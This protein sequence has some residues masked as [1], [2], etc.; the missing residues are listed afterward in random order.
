[1]SKLYVFGIGGTGSRVLKALTM[2]LSSGVECAVD[3]IVPIII[4]PDDSAADKTR[5][6]ASMNLYMS[7]RENLDFSNADQNRFFKT[8]IMPVDGME[9]FG[10]PLKN[11]R[12]CLFKD[13]IKIDELN[14]ANRALISLLFSEKN[15]NSDMK[16]GFKGNPNIGSVVLNQFANSQEYKDFANGFQQ[17]DRIFIISSIFGGTGASGFPLLLK[18]L[19][20]DRDS[21]SWNLINK[22][23]IGAITVLPYFNVSQDDNSGVDSSTFA[24]KTKSALAYYEH[25]I[26]ANG[27]VDALYYIGDNIP[28]S[29]E[30][31][32]GGSEQRNNAHII[33]LCSALAILKFAATPDSELSGDTL[34][35]EYGLDTNNTDI[36]QIIFSDLG[37]NTQVEIQKPMTQ[38]LLMY[39]YLINECEKEYKH[40]PWAIDNNLDSSFF[41]GDFYKDLME[42][43][44]SYREW[45]VEMADN[46]RAF[47]PFNI[48]RVKP[49][50]DMVVGK[51][52][53]K[54]RKLSS[55]YA[56]CDSVLN[57]NWSRWNKAAAREQ[58][59]IELFYRATKELVEHKYNM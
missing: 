48:D 14:N 25:N 18:T 30:N 19:R 52:P 27:G 31:H 2:M 13:F 40:Q 34:H 9:N 12:D 47:K 53:A 49:L 11:T 3:T 35:Y 58:K 6:V 44:D 7:I 1:M 57:S 26:S 29:Y 37:R 15:L 5:T 33:E 22:A 24:S 51:A 59:F 56:L 45:L 43:L 50:F 41:T 55:N 16:V 20:S 28:A 39:K 17:G 4:D 54:M 21:Q 32:D 46:N 42:L 10:F 23:K 38:L 36:S 8:E